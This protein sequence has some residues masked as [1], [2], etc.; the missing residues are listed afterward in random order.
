MKFSGTA[1]TSS[2]LIQLVHEE[3]NL[4]PPEKNT[5]TAAEN[6]AMVASKGGKG[7]KR[8][9]KKV[10]KSKKCAN[11][12]CLKVG[13]LAKDC[14]GKGGG[15]EGQVPWQ[16]KRK[17]STMDTATLVITITADEEAT[18]P[19]APPEPP[20][21]IDCRA[22]KH[23]SSDC[24]KFITW[25]DIVPPEPIKSTDGQILLATGQGDMLVLL[26]MGD[27][28]QPTQVTLTNTYYSA[29]MAYTL[30]SISQM[31]LKGFS[32]HLENRTCILCTPKP[33]ARVIARIPLARGLYR[34]TND[35]S[36]LT[37][38]PNH[39]CNPNHSA[40]PATNILTI[41]KF[42]RLMGHVNHNNLRKMVHDGQVTG[43]ELNMDLKPE[44][45]ETCIKAKALWKPFPIP[46]HLSKDKIVAYSSKV[47]SDVW[48]PAQVKLL[49][50]NSY[51]NSY[52]NHYSHEERVYFLKRKSETFDWY[53]KY[54]AWLRVQ[55]GAMIKV[56]RS[57]QGG[58]FTSA[59]FNDHLEKAGTVH[60]LT[61]HDSPQS[62]GGPE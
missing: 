12:N 38:N 6:A 4:R 27:N 15:R 37:N 29:Q 50:G 22:S 33:E 8:E 62:N 54:E 17:T 36:S 14:F 25:T 47:S 7:G 13:H 16:K 51:S 24:V 18:L 61:V 56:F 23:F 46:K 19:V 34:I 57:D 49:G 9:K 41:T 31:D 40:Y 21:I 45:C 30:I 32:T 35:Q 39:H 3:A 60:H 59:E 5:D 48:G 20:I 26:P 2:Q 28:A 58:E 44:F 1:M 55:R 53:K 52:L 42:H 10:D 43:V 11:L